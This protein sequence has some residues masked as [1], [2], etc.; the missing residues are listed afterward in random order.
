MWLLEVQRHLIEKMTKMDSE[1]RMKYGNKQSVNS[2]IR[3]SL[4]DKN[5]HFRQ[6]SHSEADFLSNWIAELEVAAVDGSVNQTKGEYPH[7]IYFFQALARTIKGKEKWE[8]D[9]YTPLL[10]EV[11]ETREEEIESQKRVRSSKMAELEL[12]VAKAMMEEGSIKLILMDGSLTHYAIDA[13]NF[14]KK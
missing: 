7:I 5:G 1:L 8:F 10:E 3:Q 9:L 11:E 6:M 12:M 13:Q 4:F 14:G 2:T